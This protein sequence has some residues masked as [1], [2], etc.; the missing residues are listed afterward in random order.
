[1]TLISVNNIKKS[2]VTRVLFE[3]VKFEVTER[4]R[5]GLVG[6]NGCGKT[7]LF[8]ILTGL[9]QADEGE[10]Y[11][12]R[13]A[14]IGVMEQI[15]QDLALPLYEYALL[16]FSHLVQAETEIENIN[17]RLTETKDETELDALIN[18]QHSLRERYEDGGGLTF[19]SRTRAALLGLGFTEEEMGKELSVM[20]GGQRSKAQLARVLLRDANLLLLDEPT[21]HLDIRS[22]EWL[23]DFLNSYPGAFIVISHDRYFLDKVTN[24][25]FEMRNRTLYISEGNYSRHMELKSSE[26]ELELKRYRSTQKEIKRI[27][28]VVEQ[29]RRWGQEHNFVT[30]EAKLKQ[31]ER[32]KQTLVEPERDPAKIRFSFTAKE[33]VCSEA[34][35]AEDLKKSFGDMLLFEH[36]DLLI[37][38]NEKVFLLGPNGCGKTTLL[39]I[40]MN[41]EPAD[42]GKVTV[43]A[44]IKAGYYEQHMS[45]LDPENTVLEEVWDEY[46][47]TVSHKD[48]CNALAAFLFR[49]DEI[50]KKVSCLS[51]GEQARIRLLKL[52]LSGSNLL[53]LDEPT[54]HLDID[55][56]EALESALEDYGGTMLVVTHDRYLV[57]RLSDRI[58]YL[59]GSGL[60]EYIG[61]YD[62]FTV[63]MAEKKNEKAEKPQD[64]KQSGYRLQ[65]ELKSAVNR[66][67]GE[68][69]RA[70]ERLKKAESELTAIEEK[71]ASPAVASDYVKA[72]ELSKTAD[73]LRSRIEKLYSEWDEATE[74]LKRLTSQL[75]EEAL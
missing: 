17:E 24:R 32:L 31:I 67:E 47:N 4:D 73:E 34:L 43:G 60:T 29:Q 46:Y 7:T 57:N 65:K 8:R 27:Y 54:N 16:E 61:G 30:A 14:R 23:E 41:E 2:Y 50:Q 18:R 63:A 10:L 33:A 12:N 58:L 13:E 42:D 35:K 28:G 75:G 9:E 53:L 40:I 48:I 74:A 70:E 68:A 37:H 69:R 71:L 3:D 62:E 39:K 56:R 66:A 1:M 52:M 20:S 36:L 5:V 64:K 25:T 22:T 15:A 38:K 21:N 51:G 44:K 72:M 45:A 59:D 26:R 19:R 11:I 6:V 55:S 49:G